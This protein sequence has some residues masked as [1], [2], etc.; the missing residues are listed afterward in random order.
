MFNRTT[1]SFQFSLITLFAALL[2]LG[3]VGINTALA[4]TQDKLIGKAVIKEEC[5]NGTDKPTKQTI[6]TDF[7][8]DIFKDSINLQGTD[9]CGAGCRSPYPAWTDVWFDMPAFIRVVGLTWSGSVLPGKA[10]T[11]LTKNLKNGK[12]HAFLDNLGGSDV[13]N[14]QLEINGTIVSD[15]KTGV[16]KKIAGKISGHDHTANCTYVGKFKGK[17]AIP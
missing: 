8:M 4:G 5:H 6:K 15:K 9:A 17:L 3:T 12:F 13:G 11:A 16:S 1:K 7:T 10:G 2:F 14:L